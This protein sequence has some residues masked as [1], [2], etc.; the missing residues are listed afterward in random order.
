MYTNQIEKLNRQTNT[1]LP[2][3]I[4]AI[5]PMELTQDDAIDRSNVFRPK[6]PYQAPINPIAEIVHSPRKSTISVME[7]IKAGESPSPAKLM[8]YDKD[9]QVEVA[10]VKML[11]LKQLKDNVLNILEAK[12][13]S[14]RKRAE[15]RQP[16][17]SMEQYFYAYLNQQFGLKCLVLEHANSILKSV[18]ELAHLDADVSYFGH[19]MRN[20]IDENFGVIRQRLKETIVELLR[21]CLRGKFPVK[22]DAAIVEMVVSRQADCIHEDEW[23]HILK[24]LYSPHDVRNNMH[25][26][27][28]LNLI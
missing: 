26:L 20:E 18:A 21:L 24:Y 15:A 1:E 28:V 22:S 11:S 14:D 4:S 17:E 27:L 13:H 5:R 19:L 25:H 9:K 12:K 2:Q 16:L 8:E 3:K 7:P 23:N 6:S 10:N